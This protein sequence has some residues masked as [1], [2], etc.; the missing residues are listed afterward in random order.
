MRRTAIESVERLHQIVLR[1][2]RFTNLD[3]NEILRVDLN[4]LLQDVVDIVKAG[5]KSDV[6]LELNFQSLPVVSLASA[7]NECRFF[8][9]SA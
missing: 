7:T 6:H 5:L 2:Q 4:S 1:M 3:R 9:P 8:E